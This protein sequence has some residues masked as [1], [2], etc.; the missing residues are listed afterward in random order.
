MLLSKAVELFL[1]EKQ[2][3]TRESYYYIL[4]DFQNL[5]GPARPIE[6]LRPVDLVIY[7]NEIRRRPYTPTT[8]Y[9]YIKTVKTLFNW[10]IRME[11]IATSPAAKITATK[12]PRAVS[13][14]KAITDEELKTLFAYTRF[15]PRHHALI[16]FLADTGCRIGG[17]TKLHEDDLDLPNLRAKVTEKGNKTRPVAYGEPCAQAIRSW[18]I[19]RGPTEEHFV[20]SITG[21][22]ISTAALSQLFR[23]T[24]LGCGIRSL[25][26]HSV[27][28]HKGH[29]LADL[30]IAPSIAATA[31]GHENVETTL[32]YYYPGDW[33]TAEHV[34][35]E[36]TVQ[37]TEEQS[38]VI[39]LPHQKTGHSR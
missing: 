26:P 37:P 15:K 12:P 3:T 36:L 16:L 23:R 9:K 11:L 20:F 21:K 25:G 30:R 6:T 14:E 4:K 35:R 1:N 8:V 22:S 27:R 10:C 19:R 2:G 28:H 39:K 31:L 33:E 17:A 38:N 29:Q 34:L 13:R 32:H 18:L 5:I 7:T 24:C